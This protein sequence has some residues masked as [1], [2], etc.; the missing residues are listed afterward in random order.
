MK[1]ALS[2]DS[3]LASVPN[4][5]GSFIVLHN[6]CKTHG[7]HEWMVEEGSHN[8]GGSTVA[9]ATTPGSTTATARDTRR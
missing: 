4:I 3:H 6:F 2:V 5:I 1:L 9:I 7:D 8:S